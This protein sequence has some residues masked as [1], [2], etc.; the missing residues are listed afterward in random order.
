MSCSSDNDQLGPSMA[1]DAS[2]TWQASKDP[3]SAYGAPPIARLSED[4]AS[5][6]VLSATHGIPLSLSNIS[7]YRDDSVRL[8]LSLSEHLELHTMLRCIP[9]AQLGSNVCTKQTHELLAPRAPVC[10]S[11]GLQDLGFAGFYSYS[12]YEEI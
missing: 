8:L 9:W 6:S 4:V 7:L 12:Q 1:S 2:G 5:T 10:C 3:S 11:L